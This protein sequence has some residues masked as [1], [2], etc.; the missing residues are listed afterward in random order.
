MSVNAISASA[1]YCGGI[2]GTD[3]EYQEIIRKLRAYGVAPSGDFYADKAKLNKIE[4][5]KENKNAKLDNSDAGKKTPQ[6][7]NRPEP[8]VVDKG[9]GTD[10]I[11]ML[12][13]MQLGLL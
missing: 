4:E 3:K 13:R 9:E 10:Q 6:S 1:F 11:A 2:S 8:D 5:T 12:N 7:E